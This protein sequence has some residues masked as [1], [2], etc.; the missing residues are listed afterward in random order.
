MLLGAVG[1]PQQ[2]TAARRARFEGVDRGGSVSPD[3]SFQ[4]LACRYL[5]KQLNRLFRQAAGIA[6]NDDIECVHQARVASRR[7]GTALDVFAVC[8]P[9]RRVRKWRKQI[10]RLT[11]GLGAA[12]D[13]DVQI[14]LV[15]QVAA[16]VAESKDGRLPGVERLLLRLRQERE[17]LQ[18]AVVK[19]VKRMEASRALAKLRVEVEHRRSSLRRRGA[20]PASEFALQQS[21]RQIRKRLGNLLKLQSCLDDPQA[22]SEHHRMRIAA[23]RLRYTMEICNPACGGGLGDLVKA[24]RRVQTLLGDIHDCD[25]WTERIASFIED[26]RRRT[27]E[28]FGD[29][30][31]FEALRPGLD[32]LRDERAAHRQEAFRKLVVFWEALRADGVWQDLEAFVQSPQKSLVTAARGSEDETK[33]PQQGPAIQTEIGPKHMTDEPRETTLP[34][35]FYQRG[36]RWWWRVQLPGEDKPKSRP[37]RAAGS[38]ETATDKTAALEIAAALWQSASNGAPK[39]P[40][41][42]E[43][44]GAVEATAASPAPEPSEEPAQEPVAEPQPAQEAPSAAPIDADAP[45]TPA[46]ETRTAVCECCSR[47]HLPGSDMCRIDSGQLLCPDC[48]AELRRKAEGT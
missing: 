34:G 39:E 21:A 27:V 41:D 5:R 3:T 38:Q 2:A 15:A 23:K 48:L 14:E 19:E 1:R 36:S 29:D 11:E 37:L 9:A 26:E 25:V 35:T 8:F 42:D 33:G 28:Y 12:R 13:L 30:E 7:V 10:Q 22:R 46:P 47:N 32:F 18:P 17:A 20:S 4:L 43:T 16:D 6:R 24:A 45:E 40:P 31:S 44:A